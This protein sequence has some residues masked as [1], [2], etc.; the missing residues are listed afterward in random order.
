MSSVLSR[1]TSSHLTPTQSC[2]LSNPPVCPPFGDVAERASLSQLTTLKIMLTR[3]QISQQ[4][5][6][7][8]DECLN[9]GLPS[10]VGVSPYL[11]GSEPTAAGL[12]G[13]DPLANDSGGRFTLG[14]PEPLEWTPVAEQV[15][16]L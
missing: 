1:V 11:Q 3:T 10:F 6:C 7:G 14:S 5:K 9:G 4:G 16:F 8:C 12:T 13:L 15:S 2:L